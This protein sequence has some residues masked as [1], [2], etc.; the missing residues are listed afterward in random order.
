MLEMIGNH[1]E[2]M[3]DYS[4]AV[5]TFSEMHALAIE[6]SDL[7]ARAS[8]SCHLASA[9]AA[10]GND[11]GAVAAIDQA[12]SSLPNEPRYADPQIICHLCK[13]TV[14]RM[15][16]GPALE[17][18]EAAAKRLPDLQVPN[19][20]LEAAVLSLLTGATATPCGCRRP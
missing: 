6:G 5:Q 4:H 8:S 14:Y 10:Q 16:G 12:L 20:D 18:V 1:F 11:A 15:Q 2:N 17:E 3:R 7:G 13:S 9:T 19:R